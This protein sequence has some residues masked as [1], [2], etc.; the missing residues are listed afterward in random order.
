[1]SIGNSIQLPTN[2]AERLVKVEGLNANSVSAH[3]VNA[4]RLN[5]LVSPSV[6]KHAGYLVRRASQLGFFVL[7]VDEDLV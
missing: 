5:L 2:L 1:M 4:V 7:H 3:A 6:E